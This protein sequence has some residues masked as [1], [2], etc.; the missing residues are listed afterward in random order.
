MKV[1]RFS[2]PRTDKTIDMIMALALAI[3]LVVPYARAFWGGALLLYVAPFGVFCLAFLLKTLSS[4]LSLSR[5]SVF[6]LWISLIVVAYYLF[7]IFWTHSSDKYLTN[8][9]QMVLWIPLILI[10]LTAFK[11]SSIEY[12]IYIYLTLAF[13]IAIDVF[14]GYSS[15]G[16]ISG[17]DAEVSESYLVAGSTL[18]AAATLATGMF[19]YAST[20]LGK[21][22]TLICMGTLFLAVSFSLAR[23]ALLFSIFCSLSLIVV[24]GLSE[25]KIIAFKNGSILFKPVTF[26]IGICLAIAITFSL[27]MAFNVDRTAARLQR[28]F[29]GHELAQGGRGFIWSNGLENFQNNPYFGYGLGSSGLYSAG[30]EHSYPHNFILQALLDGGLLGFLGIFVV[31]ILSG[32]FSF[33]Y[34]IK[35]KEGFYLVPWFA[36]FYFVLEYSKSGDFYSARPV[37]VFLCLSLCAMNSKRLERQQEQ[38]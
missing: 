9:L 4:N 21:G 18:G 25:K 32:A 20:K 26:I 31:L 15:V 5:F 7:S 33:L 2:T 14:I 6:Y 28:L 13:F 19:F 17:Y 27:Y 16:D 34:C 29:S 8:A 12:F 30:V 24:L 38:T 10:S 3:L 22:F 37:F 1:N 36:F 11:K 35:R 23:G